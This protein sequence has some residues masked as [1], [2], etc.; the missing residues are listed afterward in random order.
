MRLKILALLL[1]L[2]L[3]AGCSMHTRYTI[4]VDLASFFGDL[5][6]DFVDFGTTVDFELYLP[7]DEDGDLNTPDLDGMLVRNPIPGDRFLERVYLYATADFEETGGESLDLIVEIYVAPSDTTD[8]YHGDGTL[9]GEGG[10]Q[11]NPNAQGTFD[12]ALELVAGDDGF[13][14]ISQGDFRFGVKLS[15]RGKSFSYRV[16]NFRFGLTTQPVGEIVNP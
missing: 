13:G 16:T 14:L 1:G 2:A 7:D 4:N 5:L 11:L 6:S 10:I 8:L 12:F 15:G 9:I 3:L